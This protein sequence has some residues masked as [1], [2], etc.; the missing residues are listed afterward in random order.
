[1]LTTKGQNNSNTLE[2]KH[3]DLRLI[4]FS[5]KNGKSIRFLKEEFMTELLYWLYIAYVFLRK[6][7]V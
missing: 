3:R 7:T 4:F 5:N 2:Y 6:Y 1:M